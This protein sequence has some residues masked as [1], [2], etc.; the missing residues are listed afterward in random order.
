MTYSIT[1][2]LIMKMRGFLRSAV[3]LIQILH[4]TT[5]LN[6]H[7]SNAVS[8]ARICLSFS[9]ESIASFSDR[10]VASSK[11]AQPGILCTRYHTEPRCKMP[12][13]EERTYSHAQALSHAYACTYLAVFFFQESYLNT[14]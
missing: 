14:S 12:N 13:C 1:V 3:Q 5:A 4:P 2:F 10:D 6:L 11:P 7:I 8:A 9:P